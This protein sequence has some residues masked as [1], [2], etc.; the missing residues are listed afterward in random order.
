MVFSDFF[1]ALIVLFLGSFRRRSP[2]EPNI[3]SKEDISA[4]MGY[5]IQYSV[6]FICHIHFSNLESVLVLPAYGLQLESHRGLSIPFSDITIS[7]STNRRFISTDTI[8]D[9]LVN[10]GLWTW[11]WHYYLVVLTRTPHFERGERIQKDGEPFD[12][13]LLVAFEVSPSLFDGT[14]LPFNIFYC[15]RKS[16]LILK[17]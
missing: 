12:V 9:V 4:S 15:I 8:Q 17:W 6:T 14:G 13:K 10:E 7:L 1:L 16:F 3:Y 5:S 2:S 11:N